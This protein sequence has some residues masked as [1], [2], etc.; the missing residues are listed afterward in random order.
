MIYHN[1]NKLSYSQFNNVTV[2]SSCWLWYTVIHISTVFI[3]IRGVGV[4]WNMCV[5]YNKYS[6]SSRGIATLW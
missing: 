1:K 3:L 4:Y 2:A 5:Y 6:L